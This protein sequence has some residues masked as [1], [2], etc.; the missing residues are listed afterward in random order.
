MKQLLVFAVLIVGALCQSPCTVPNQFMTGMSQI[1]FDTNECT[2]MSNVATMYYDYPNQ[3]L[4]ID[5]TAMISG[6]SYTLTAWLDYDKEMGYYYDRDTEECTSSPISG[7]L[8]D[9]QLPD[10]SE[11]MGTVLIGTQAVDNWLTPDDDETGMYG[12]VG[13]AETTCW[14][15][16]E[17]VLNDTNNQPI[18]NQN[19]WDFMPQLPPFYFDMPESCMNAKVVANV[20][21]RLLPKIQIRF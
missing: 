15:V 16:F 12:Y 20:P 6:N 21:E 2:S 14:P 9:P 5:E 18:F 17:Y 1:M 8:Q 19:F 4:R 11:Y 10:D 7:E 13:L 3:Q